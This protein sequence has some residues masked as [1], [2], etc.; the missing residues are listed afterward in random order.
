MFSAAAL[1]QAPDSSSLGSAGN[2]CDAV[3]VVPDIK[4]KEEPMRIKL[5]IAAA[6]LVA[7]VTP[8]LAAE[9]FIVQ[10]TSTKRCTIVEQRPTTSTMIVVGPG[11]AYATR[12]EAETSM[13]T[14][15]VC[16][17]GGTVGGPM[18]PAPR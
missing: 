6:A 13:K 10:D 15:K 5:V 14:V 11:G 4:E 2:Q 9:F 3:R 12:A 8:S 17:T 1:A 18:A 16:E 7:S